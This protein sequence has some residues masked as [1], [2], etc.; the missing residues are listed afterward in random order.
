MQCITPQSFFDTKLAWRSCLSEFDLPG[1]G[2]LLGGTR[3]SDLNGAMME[4]AVW[5]TPS[6]TQFNLPRKS[7][8][9]FSFLATASLNVFG[10]F[11]GAALPDRS[12]SPLAASL[13]NVGSF[14]FEIHLIFEMFFFSI[15]LMVF[16]LTLS[17]SSTC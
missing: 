3:P 14:D 11:E 8:T 4:L 6:F 12:M 9:T 13:K 16:I 2:N 5:K 10:H 7:S 17:L 15:F 1:A